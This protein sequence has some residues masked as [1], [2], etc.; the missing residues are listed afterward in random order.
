MGESVFAV[1][2]LRLPLDLRERF[3]AGDGA[4]S[5][6]DLV[7]LVG[8]DAV[9]ASAFWVDAGP[10]AAVRW[11]LTDDFRRFAAAQSGPGAAA[12]AVIEQA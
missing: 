9:P 5:M 12:G 8:A 6:R 7:A 11:V 4:L 3:A 10:G 2:W 1:V